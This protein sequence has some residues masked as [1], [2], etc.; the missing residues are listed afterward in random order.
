MHPVGNGWEKRGI[1]LHQAVKMP[2]GNE[3]YDGYIGPAT[4]LGAFPDTIDQL[5]AFPSNKDRDAA[6]QMVFVRRLSV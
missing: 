5:E 4:L 3:Q 6:L 1:D 2:S